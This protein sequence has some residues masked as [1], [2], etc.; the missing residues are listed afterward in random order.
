MTL[1]YHNLPYSK[2][3][4]ENITVNDSLF[5]KYIKMQKK[6]GLLPTLFY[7]DINKIVFKM[8]LVVFEK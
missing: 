2:S 6:Q 4:N 8:T 7:K 1:I 3:P 5:P